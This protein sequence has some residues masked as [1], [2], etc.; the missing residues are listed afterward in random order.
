[1]MKRNK[2]IKNNLAGNLLSIIIKLINYVN[3][4]VLKVKKPY[5]AFKKVLN[6]CTAVIAL[7]LH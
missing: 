2:S 4:A 3:A 7:V 1:M 5:A 6:P